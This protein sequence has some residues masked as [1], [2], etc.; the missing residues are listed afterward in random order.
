MNLG[1]MREMSAVNERF[2][3]ATWV[4]GLVGGVV[5]ATSALSSTVGAAASP[6]VPVS[7]AVGHTSP[8]EA[9]L[10]DTPAGLLPNNLSGVS[11][12]SSSDC[13][14][15]GSYTSDLSVDQ[16]LVESWNGSFWSVI[17]SPNP[18]DK[19]ALDA[20]SCTS[21]TDCVAVGKYASGSSMDSTLIEAW[22]GS[23]WLVD[24]S[25]NAGT[26][27]ENDLSGV[28]CTSSSDCVAVG[29]ST[30]S[31]TESQT[32]IESW[33]GTAWS[34]AS[35]P[36][37]GTSFDDLY[38]VS[39]IGS[40]YCVAVGDSENP[41]DYPQTLVESWNGTAWSV[42]TSPDAGSSDNDLYAVSCTSTTACTAVGTYGK[43][44]NASQ[45]SVPQTLV[46]SWNGA[47]WAVVPSPDGGGVSENDLA[48]VSCSSATSCLAVGTYVNPALSSV[49][50]VDDTLVESW[51]GSAWSVVPSPNHGSYT[52]ELS[53]VS[54]TA[55]S[56][57][58]AV[59]LYENASNYSQTLIEAWDGASWVVVASPD[60]CVLVGPA[61]S[62]AAMPAGDGYWLVDGSGDISTH[63]VALNYGSTTDFNL[64]APIVQIVATRTAAATG[65]W[66][67]TGESSV[68]ET[69][70]STVRWEESP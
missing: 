58:V 11:C 14:A 2:M 40:A 27:N 7:A 49:Y 57:C 31:E 4:V 3:R 25:P 51:N 48:D 6:A 17:P 22:N 32:L 39:C 18:G 55:A 54:C 36:N 43:L 45:S 5:M 46:E 21:S 50:V 37:P 24:P 64:N 15:V 56:N 65:W 9:K 66:R 8:V 61:V 38:A 52:N 47:A 42:V 26:S 68:S 67:P 63:G 70:V 19:D 44:F 23:A 53:A 30:S 29:S 41:S 1:T 16:T 28:S 60:V 35:S 20:V 69:P 34:L 13:V 62:M 59:G 12:I 10:S 33:N